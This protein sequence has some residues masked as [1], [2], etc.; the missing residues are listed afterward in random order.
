LI[1]SGM[2]D[3]AGGGTRFASVRFGNVL[4]S[5]GSVIPLFQ[6]QIARGG[7][8]T[9]THPDMRRYFMTTR[10]AVQLVL[11][12]SIM[13]KGSE[14]FLLDMGE[15]VRIVDLAR[16]M[17]RLAGLEPE[18]DIEFRFT[19]L[20]P[21][22]RLFEELLTDT[23]DVIATSHPK[24]KVCRVRRVGREQLQCWMDELGVLLQRRDAAGVMDNLVLHIPEYC[25]P[26]ATARKVLVATAGGSGMVLRVSSAD[27]EARA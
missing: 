14:T 1:V 4:G 2:S 19:G 21:G 15:P 12:A 17:V 8:I 11:Q 23:D 9:I 26:A 20:R 13:A 10:E 18:E 22:E 25:R 24:I 7:P 16:H 27:S 6:T 3:G 5:N